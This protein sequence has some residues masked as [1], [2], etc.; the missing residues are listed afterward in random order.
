MNQKEKVAIVTGSTAGIGFAI[1]KRLGLDGAK[2]VVSS[3]KQQNVEKAVTDLRNQGISVE[4]VVCN[5]SKQIDRQNLIDFTLSKYG[6]ID[7]L[8]NNAG[9]NP[10]FGSLLD[11]S[12]Q[13]W[14]K[15]FETNLKSG[16][17][18]S[19]LVVPIMEKQGSGNIVFVSSVSGYATI[20]GIAAYG[21]TKTAMLGLVKALSIECASMNIRVNC[22]APGIIKTE[23]SKSL[24]EDEQIQKYHKATIPL[25]RL[26]TSDDCAGA[27][28]FLCSDQASFITGETIVISGGVQS[29]L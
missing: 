12:E 9:I 11:V 15:L 8:I 10:A 25:R 2:I 18:L 23:F 1:A 6:R 24:W 22:I 29:R 19:K 27:V 3:R 4:G 26:G 13:I 16:F 17:L 5:V 28:S 14:D 21:I 7:I 20:P